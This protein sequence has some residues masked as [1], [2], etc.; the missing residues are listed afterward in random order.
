[1]PNDQRVSILLVDDDPSNLEAL[2]AILESLNQNLV[3]ASSGTEALRCVLAQDFA[4]IL[5]D[6][7]MPDMGGI[8]AAAMIRQRERSKTTP[9][10][11]LTGVV[12]T[13]EMMF[14]GCSTGAVDYLMKPVDSSVLRTKVAAFVELALARQALQAEI[15]ERVRIAGELSRLDTVLEQQR[16]DLL[17]AKEDLEAFSHSLSHDLRVPLRHI[18]AY[19][20][21][22]EDSAAT[23]LDSQEQQRL[24]SAR[25]AAQRMSQLIEDLLS[26]S[27]VG[28]APLSSVPV[29]MTELVKGA[30]AE[31]QPDTRERNIEWDLGLLPRVRGDR[32]L[33]HQVW[34]NLLSNA[35]KYTRPREPASIQVAAVQQDR[36]LI[37]RVKDNGV[38]FDM[39]YAEKLFGVFQRM[40]TAQ[41]FEGTGIGLASVRRIIQRHGGRTWA[42][43]RRNEGTTIFFSLPMDI[44]QNA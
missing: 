38:G 33:L 14:K 36:E 17:T 20:T 4:V 11:F 9:I 44:D 3:C 5:L 7:Q 6:V 37:F 21:M 10:I 40:H 12:K 13:G 31:L 24:Q 2:Q 1:M 41:E 34:V 26:F 18:Q 19:I 27:R 22:V 35:I 42:E 32:A 43:A 23:K 8:E 25:N 16:N 39:G 15:R 30:L 29:D 28:C